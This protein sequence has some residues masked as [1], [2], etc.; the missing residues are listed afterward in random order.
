LSLRFS[1]WLNSPKRELEEFQIIR[2]LFLENFYQIFL[3]YKSNF[4]TTKKQFNT[5]DEKFIIWFYKK[6]NNYF[7]NNRFFQLR[8]K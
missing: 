6:N 7:N 3:L 5:F 4:L 1:N 2:N 8:D